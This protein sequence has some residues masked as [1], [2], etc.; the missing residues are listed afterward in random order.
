MKNRLSTWAFVLT[1][2][3]LIFVG[4]GPATAQPPPVASDD[5]LFFEVYIVPE[6]EAKPGC[7]PLVVPG[8]LDFPTYCFDES[9]RSL[10][11]YMAPDPYD[12]RFDASL[13]AIVGQAAIGR[14]SGACSHLEPICGLPYSFHLRPGYGHG[15]SVDLSEV[16][17]IQ[18]ADVTG[19]GLLVIRFDNQS[20]R[21]S[22][23]DDWSKQ[24]GS[25]G[26][27]IYIVNHGFLDKKTN[28]RT[29]RTFFHS[30]NYDLI[31]AQSRRVC[32]V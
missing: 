28:D 22:P 16:G 14:K 26:E 9:N 32:I 15:Y 12:V 27:R 4:C 1:L 23:G 19:S 13:K 30:F 5:F 17:E 24:V 3:A 29:L 31:F 18:V 7:R 25:C 20:V 2:G 21:L 6:N 8:S 11:T 10:Y